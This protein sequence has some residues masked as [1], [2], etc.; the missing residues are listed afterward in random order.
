MVPDGGLGGERRG[1]GSAV[2]PARETAPQ[3]NMVF[4]RIIQGGRGVVPEDKGCIGGT[5]WPRKRVQG[6]SEVGSEGT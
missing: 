2:L 4:R 5:T 6:Q 3:K 1:V